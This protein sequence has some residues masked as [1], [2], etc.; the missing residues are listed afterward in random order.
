MQPVIRLERYDKL[1]AEP[2]QYNKSGGQNYTMKDD[3]QNE[4]RKVET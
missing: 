4:T 3:D 2:R 1:Y